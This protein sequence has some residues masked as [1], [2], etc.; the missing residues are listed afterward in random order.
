MYSIRS[1]VLFLFSWLL[2]ALMPLKAAQLPDFTHLA[3]SS[4][5]AVVNISTR[6]ADKPNRLPHGL[7][8]PD[9]PEGPWQDLFRHFFGEQGRKGDGPLRE[10]QSLGSGFILS[11]DGYIVTNY[12]V[13]NGADEI[14]VRL[15]DRREFV[16]RVIGSDE[17]SD[18]AL[19][20]VDA[21]D[22]PVAKIG[23]SRDLKVGEW[24]VAIGSPF[25]FDHSV[26]AG[27]I[28]ALGRALPSENYVPFIQTDVAI[29]PGNSGGPLFNLSGEVIGINSQ[30]YSQTGG[31]MGLSFAIPIDVAMEAVTQIR[32]S[33]HVRRGWLGVLIQDVTRELAESFGMA[34]PA[35]ALV[36]KVVDGSP[37]K[38]AGVRV[39]DIILEFDGRKIGVSAELPPLVGRTPI[40]SQVAV[41]VLRNGKSQT[42]RL[43]IGELPSSDEALEPQPLESVIQPQFDLIGLRVEEV[44]GEL[45]Q[46][47]GLASGGVVIVESQQGSGANAG[48]EVGDIIVKINGIDVESV[49]HYREL[50]AKL[51]RGRSVPLLVMR[52]NGPLFL[53]MRVPQ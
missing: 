29:N 46:A 42:L 22:L 9:L 4:S 43:T 3:E 23:T 53:A 41:K 35:G 14:I 12:H 31:F 34:T 17:R 21:N 24:V 37:A 47:I 36:A 10:S 40:D 8:I 25:G 39:G 18:V 20:K 16:A 6:Q 13:V 33:G 48:L 50:L 49:A 44:S 28:S 32:E 27:I 26:S 30:I 15:S 19:I 7:K 1:L 5:P 52:E 51:P 38:A 11:A 2:L 45:R